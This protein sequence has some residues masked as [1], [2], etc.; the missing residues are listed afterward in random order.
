MQRTISAALESA[1]HTRAALWQAFAAR[2]EALGATVMQ[3]AGEAEAADMLAGA[4]AV[5]EVSATG[6]LAGRFPRAA[7][8]CGG[9]AAGATVAALRRPES[10]ATA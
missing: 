10:G 7:A 8:A 2:A 1:A 4:A 6:G 3:A 9:P 5:G